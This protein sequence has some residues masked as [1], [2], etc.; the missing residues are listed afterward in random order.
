M[1]SF[2]DTTIVSNIINDHSAA[3]FSINKFQGFFRQ[4][5]LPL[6]LSGQTFGILT[7]TPVIPSEPLP[8]K[9][10]TDFHCHIAGMGY[11]DSG[12]FISKKLR[13]S[14]KF[15]Y[16]LKAMHINHKDV[17]KQGDSL[18]IKQLSRMI[19]KSQYVDR[20]VV[21]AIDGK[22]TNGK[23][24]KEN[25]EYYI[26]NEFVYKETRKYDNLLFGA[27]INPYRSDAIEQLEW[28][29]ENG[30]VLIK[31]I[32]SI[33]N[34][35]PSDPAIIP[36]YKK[37]LDLD[38]PLLIH[39]G[40]ERSFTGSRH[41]L[42]DPLK[43]ELPLKLGLTV[44]AAHIATTGTSQGQDNYERILPLFDKYPNLYGDISSLTQVN[45]LSYLKKVLKENRLKGRLIY[46]T[47][48]PLQSFPVITPFAFPSRLTLAQMIHIASMTNDW[49]RDVILKQTLGMDSQVFTL[50]EKIIP[51]QY[52]SESTEK[53]KN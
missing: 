1:K 22:V 11:G 24:D 29:K 27:S 30:A 15:S 46:G 25:T 5:F 32:P 35:D 26:P 23:L 13:H 28:A 43:I 37:I 44:I 51:Y 40:Q 2:F 42:E 52:S 8:P 31:W 3:A 21:L 49:D 45:K 18:I 47:D 48:W 53:I 38:L 16:Y 9:A 4:L 20:A 17:K 41:D 50:G 34:I 14:F 36:F 12:C 10:F 39:T 6:F 19:S 7:Y 33:M